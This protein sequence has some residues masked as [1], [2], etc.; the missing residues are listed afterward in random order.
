MVMPAEAPGDHPKKLRVAL[1]EAV[2]TDK[3]KAKFDV[4]N[5]GADAVLR[6]MQLTLVGGNSLAI[7]RLWYSSH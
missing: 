3:L 1:E 7:L 5:F 6:G 2:D 4:S